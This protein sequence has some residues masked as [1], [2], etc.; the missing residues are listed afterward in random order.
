MVKSTFEIVLAAV[1]VTGGIGLALG[2]AWRQ[3][4]NV[5][6]NDEH[7]TLSVGTPHAMWGGG[8]RTGKPLCS[9]RAY[10]VEDSSFGPAVA[11]MPC[12]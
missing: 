8:G 7:R 4:S 9:T 6:C 5:G 12:G 11:R 3:W 1:F 2:L 10:R